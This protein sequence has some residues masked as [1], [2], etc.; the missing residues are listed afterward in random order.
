M[1]SLF[2]DDS[3]KCPYLQ[4][5]Y[6]VD[7]LDETHR[8]LLIQICSHSRVPFFFHICLS[9]QSLGRRIGTSKMHLSPPP[10]SRSKAVVLLLLI[11]CLLLLTLYVGVSC[12]EM[13]WCYLVR[14]VLCSFAI[15]LM[16]KRESWLLFYIV[17]LI[18]CDC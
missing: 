15:I 10:P 5:S 6:S 14:Y 18:F 13:L 2:R 12:L 1:I 16:G 9:L 3:R 4:Y 17:F 11:R 7:I 8:S